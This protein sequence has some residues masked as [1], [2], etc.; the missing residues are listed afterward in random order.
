MGFVSLRRIQ[1]IFYINSCFVLLL[2]QPNPIYICNIYIR[3]IIKIATHQHIGIPTS[4]M[5]LGSISPDLKKNVFIN[6]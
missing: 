5:G 4:N 3:G 2:A 1:I 6:K